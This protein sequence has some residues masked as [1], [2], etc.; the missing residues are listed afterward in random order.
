M[1]TRT[2]LKAGTELRFPGMPCRI[3]TFMGRG[4]NSLVYLGE[5]ED[6]VSLGQWHDVIIKELFPLHPNGAVY[7]DADGCIHVDPEGRS[8]YRLHQESFE[9]GNRIHLKLLKDNPAMIGGNVNT[10]A[11]NGTLYTLLNCS[12]SIGFDAAMQ[13][14][15]VSLRKIVERMLCLTE[16]LEVFHQSGLLHLDI[17]PD[18]ILM[19]PQ[20]QRE[21]ILLIDF[22]SASFCEEWQN[23]TMGFCSVKHGYTAPEICNGDYARVGVHS[24][25]YSV[26]AIFYSCLMGR[27]LTMEEAIRSSPPDA[28]ESKY[29]KDASE[30]VKHMVKSIL[31]RGL[32]TL[33]SRRYAAIG[34]LRAD[35][36]ELLARID[37][38]GVTHWAVY[39][40]AKKA[41]NSFIKANPTFAFLGQKD[42]LFPLNFCDERTGCTQELTDFLRECTA[43]RT[44]LLRANG[45]QGKTTALLYAALQQNASYS[46]KKMAAVYLSAY[47][48]RP[49]EKWFIHDNILRMLKFDKAT[50]DYPAARHELDQLLAR[51]L[52]DGKTP[53]LLILLDGMNEIACDTSLLIQELNELGA[54]PG[55]SITVSSRSDIPGLQAIPYSLNFLSLE[56]VEEVLSTRGIL[57]PEDEEV[58]QILRTPLMLSMFIRTSQAIGQQ[59][60]IATADELIRSLLQMETNRYTEADDE[61]W[62]M[63]AAVHYVL[64]AIAEQEIVRN[65]ML[66]E[67]ELQ[68]TVARC[69]QVVKSQALIRFFPRWIGH[70]KAIRGGAKNAEEWYAVIV[71]KLLWR[72]AGMLIRDENGMYRVFHQQIKEWLKEVNRENQRHLA[73]QRGLRACAMMA[74]LLAVG[75]IA[76][77]TIWIPIIQPIIE[78]AQVVYFPKGEAETVVEGAQEVCHFGKTVGDTMMKCLRYAENRDMESFA[79]WLP[80]A[81]DVLA[82][83]ASYFPAD[84]MVACD[85]LKDA[86]SIQQFRDAQMPWS[87]HSFQYELFCDLATVP[88]DMAA[89]YMASLKVLDW[90]MSNDTMYDKYAKEYIARL[91]ELV[92]CDMEIVYHYYDQLVRLELTAMQE[93]DSSL[94]YELTQRYSFEMGTPADSDTEISLLKKTRSDILLPEINNHGAVLEY[95]GKLF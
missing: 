58:Q 12:G 20:G 25:L 68:K 63:D 57:I 90:L 22:N 11:W 81:Q 51:P 70:S 48:Y 69:Y 47:A 34:T 42:A 15:D 2:Y 35:L 13:Q 18:N 44:I 17:S 76:W 24:D 60:Q 1:D 49:E 30:P 71:H 33:V 19:I 73:K 64:P 21:H 75:G 67:Q 62:Q 89:Q 8:L 77:Q 79:M 46:P 94:F 91:D 85:S 95:Q 84:Y 32:Q 54:M 14:N 41:L 80:A 29:L 6:Q 72:R 37:C 40:N 87:K 74:V 66:T 16:A 45:G 50:K 88:S 31:R 5:Y 27:P 78:Q 9:R 23:G 3:K 4:S 59:I 93:S 65:R 39:E 86:V 53:A 36:Q 10:Y 55:V 38:V 7:R 83:Y 26:T 28:A 52:A 61:H 56:E 82:P 43:A 92:S